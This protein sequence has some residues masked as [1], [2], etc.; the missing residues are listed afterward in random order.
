[1][2]RGTNFVNT[3][4]HGDHSFFLHPFSILTVAVDGQC[5]IH[6]GWGTSKHFATDKIAS[7]TRVKITG[8]TAG[9]YECGF[10]RRCGYIM[11]LVSMRL[12]LL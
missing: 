4:S 3:G 11:F 8:T 7:V 5:G 1:M 12:K 6:F 2:T 9:A 10:G